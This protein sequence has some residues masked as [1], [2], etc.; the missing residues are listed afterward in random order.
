[1]RAL[2]LF[3]LLATTAAAEDCGPAIE[4]A[5]QA[6]S[7]PPGLLRAVGRVESGRR[8]AT[9]VEPWPWALNAG[10]AG[11]LLDSRDDAVARLRQL[12]AAGHRSIDIGCLQVNLHHHPQAF[13]NPE[14]GFSPALNAAYAARFLRRLQ[15]ETGD[16]MQAV[17]RYHSGDPLRGAAYR[18][19]VAAWLGGSMPAGSAPVTAAPRPLLV[20]QH[21]GQ[22]AAVLWLR[23]PPGLPRV[24]RP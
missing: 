18:A 22:A 1:M 6:E 9:G 13:A 21:P 16:W 17:A 23:P 8:S 14:D 20:A 3:L 24:F 4:A 5:E 7:L 15:A 12:Q 11:F 19:R 10:G 2:L